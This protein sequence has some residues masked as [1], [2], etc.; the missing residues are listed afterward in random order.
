MGKYKELIKMA[1]ST[2]TFATSMY[3]NSF[4]D[5]EKAIELHKDCLLYNV[6][7]WQKT[8]E[9]YKDSPVICRYLVSNQSIPF[10]VIET[11]YSRSNCK[12]KWQVDILKRKDIT[13]EM[14]KKVL[15]NIDKN[16][17]NIFFNFK[18]NKEEVPS[19]VYNEIVKKLHR[20]IRSGTINVPPSVAEKIALEKTD[21]STTI[22][23]LLCLESNLHELIPTAII[24]NNYIYPERNDDAYKMGYVPSGIRTPPHKIARDLY[25]NVAEADSIEPIEKSQE[26]VE[27]MCNLIENHKLT[28]DEEIDLMMRCI[29][30]EKAKP[31]SSKMPNAVLECLAKNTLNEKVV[32]LYMSYAYSRSGNF[33]KILY[34]KPDL[35]S[36][37]ASTL[38]YILIDDLYQVNKLTFNDWEMKF[39]V[40]T[41]GKNE[42]LHNSLYKL[43]TEIATEKVNESVSDMSPKGFQQLSQIIKMIAFSKNTPQE[44]KDC[45]YDSPL[46]DA[47]TYINIEKCVNEKLKETFIDGGKCVQDLFKW[48]FI[49]D[50]KYM[51]YPRNYTNWSGYKEKINNALEE[52]K[53]NS[54]TS[55]YYKVKSLVT[56]TV[57]SDISAMQS[58]LHVVHTDYLR[59]RQPSHR[60]AQL[61]AD[62]DEECDLDIIKFIKNAE[63]YQK[64]LKDIEEKE[65][66]IKEKII[67]DRIKIEVYDR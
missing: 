30:K 4:K 52:A 46:I 49:G 40:N 26:T 3:K 38:M 25:Q 5:I 9:E 8:I 59:N 66:S 16:T 27:L 17:L 39:I 35:T 13:T 2:N 44:V 14:A 12:E 36:D 47:A 42:A 18:N 54:K 43:I 33:I 29:N 20:K 61:I 60:R 6:E 55:K 24:N 57:S 64:I 45:L 62:I 10:Y 53:E 63:K 41:I 65:Q 67:N 22:F 7:K 58:A 34:D 19:L 15:S 56:K 51:L 32:D 31:A 21:D 50:D 1:S 11:L 48:E 28:E 37:S 23:A